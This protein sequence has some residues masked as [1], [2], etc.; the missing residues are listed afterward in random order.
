MGNNFGMQ[1]VPQQVVTDYNSAP[2]ENYA[3][4]QPMLDQ[5]DMMNTGSHQHQ[6]IQD[7]LQTHQLHQDQL[8]RQQMQQQ[9][10]MGMPSN[11]AFDPVNNFNSNDTNILQKKLLEL[12]AE[13]GSLDKEYDQLVEENKQMQEQN[14]RIKN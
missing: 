14:D 4:G 10:E 6:Y 3:G 5:T 8:A 7:N 2:G 1:G 11:L 12:Q 9:V 13:L